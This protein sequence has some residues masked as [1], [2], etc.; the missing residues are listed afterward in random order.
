[1][2][3]PTISGAATI[4]PVDQ[5]ARIVAQDVVDELRK[6]SQYLPLVQQLAGDLLG[7]LVSV[8]A[9]Q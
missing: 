2:S 8:T 5:A 9:P 7:A 6:S 3:T 1:M 4:S